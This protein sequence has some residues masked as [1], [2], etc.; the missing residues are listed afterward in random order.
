MDFCNWTN[1][2]SGDDFDWI[3]L[4]SR[5]PSSNTGPRKDRS[6]E[7]RTLQSSLAEIL[8]GFFLSVVGEKPN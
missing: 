8:D 7:G 1:E 3:R 6:G 2:T 4:K 5:T